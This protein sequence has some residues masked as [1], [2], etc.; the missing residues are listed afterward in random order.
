V[1]SEIKCDAYRMVARIENGPCDALTRSGLDWTAKYPAM[2]AASRSSR[3]NTAYIDGEL[4]GVR[5]NSVTSFEIVEPRWSVE[6][7]DR[8]AGRRASRAAERY[9]AI[10]AQV[11]ASGTPEVRT[12]GVVKMKVSSLYSQSSP[13]LRSSQDTNVPAELP[14]SGTA[15]FS[16]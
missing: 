9:E 8:A 14:F 11:E 4:C 13:G 1:V 6:R 16:T 10:M 7:R 3:S 2:A 12:L 15:P 5:P